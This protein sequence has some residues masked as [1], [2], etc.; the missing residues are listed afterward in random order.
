MFVG[1][2]ATFGPAVIEIEHGG[3]RIDAQSVGAIAIEPE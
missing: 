1:D 3:D 2:P